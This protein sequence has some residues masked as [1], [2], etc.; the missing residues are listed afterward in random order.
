MCA[1]V[2]VFDLEVANDLPTL[3]H[4]PGRKEKTSQR[5]N[6]F[7]PHE[8]FLALRAPRKAA[9]IKASFVNNASKGLDEDSVGW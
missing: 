9:L 6:Q 8:R 2:F 1:S 7:A 3:P 5:L 4:L